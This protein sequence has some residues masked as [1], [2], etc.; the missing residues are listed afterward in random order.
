VHEGGRGDGGER[1]YPALPHLHEKGQSKEKGGWLNET[2]KNYVSQVSIIT[3]PS[4]TGRGKGS[5]T[6]DL[7]HAQGP[8]GTRVRSLGGKLSQEEVP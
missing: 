5:S 8:S 6:A 3:E 7:K 4:A 1:D 2:K